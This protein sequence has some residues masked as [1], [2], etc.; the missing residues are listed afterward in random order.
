MLAK[1]HK[2]ELIST[3]RLKPTTFLG[4]AVMASC[5][6]PP[7][8]NAAESMAP[9]KVTVYPL[10]KD[11]YDELQKGNYL[12]AVQTLCQA[13]IL[14]R[15]DVSARRY[16]ALALIKADNADRALEQMGL[17]G[18][19]TQPTAFDFFIYGEAYF[20]LGKYKE[21]Q[22]S[23]RKSLERDPTSDTARAGVIKSLVGA[24][25]WDKAIAECQRCI[26]LAKTKDQ[27]TY[28]QTMLKKVKDAKSAPPPSEE[29]ETIPS[30]IP[31]PT[32]Q[33]TTAASPASSSGQPPATSTPTAAPAAPT[34]PAAPSTPPVTVPAQAPGP[35][36]NPTTTTPVTP[37]PKAPPSPKMMPPITPA[38]IKGSNFKKTY[39]AQASV[40]GIPI[41]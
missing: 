15:D 31:V 28:F 30:T 24:L 20:A 23:Y 29:E 12:D 21:A 33:T 11:G 39:P 34:T 2:L 37:L 36:I 19:L 5:C 27:K 14:D 25:E 10:V 6:L 7:G 38:P 18:R 13:V 4:M 3:R 22:E 26:K 8:A 17:V 40:R 9:L 1:N 35:Q 16:L 32:P 41:W